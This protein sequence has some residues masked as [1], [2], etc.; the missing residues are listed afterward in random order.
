MV[1]KFR[2]VFDHDPVFDVW[3]CILGWAAFHG[4]WALQLLQ[5]ISPVFRFVVKWLLAV[6]TSSV[7]GPQ[8]LSLALQPLTEDGH[9][10]RR[11]KL[12]FISGH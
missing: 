3:S 9:I 12:T 11:T 5:E 7:N 8:T 1:L 2:L 10:K 4:A 6:P